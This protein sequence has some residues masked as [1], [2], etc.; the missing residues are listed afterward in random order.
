MKNHSLEGFT[1]IAMLIVIVV[2]GILAAILIPNLLQARISANKRAIQAHRA[3]AYKALSAAVAESPLASVTSI[4]SIKVNQNCKNAVNAVGLGGSLSTI[5]Y[6]WNAAPTAVV[7]C[8][9]TALRQDF[10]V[11]VTGDASTGPYNSVN[12]R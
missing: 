8:A 11:T 1:L 4:Q 6:G 5:N 7:S 10:I 9:V 3:N 2:I 12:G